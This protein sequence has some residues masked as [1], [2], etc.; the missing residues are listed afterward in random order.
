METSP[1]NVGGQLPLS[2]AWLPP[3]A[4]GRLGSVFSMTHTL[5]CPQ[6]A[7][8]GRSSLQGAYRPGRPG[9]EEG[10]CVYVCA[11]V[12]VLCVWPVCGWADFVPRTALVSETGA[13]PTGFPLFHKLTQSQSSGFLTLAKPPPNL[14]LSQPCLSRDSSHRATSL[15]GHRPQ[16]PLLE[17]WFT[18][19]SGAMV[20][21]SPSHITGD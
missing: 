7:S 13:R 6:T 8:V 14:P 10:W 11:L 21:H 4:Q 17:N 19:T 12:C 3:R 9:K 16:L 15:P 20:P 2:R 5:S 1:R 18:G